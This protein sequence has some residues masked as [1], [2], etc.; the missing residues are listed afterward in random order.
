MRPRLTI[1]ASLVLI[2]AL[3]LYPAVTSGAEAERPL[4]LARQV[5]IDTNG[6]GYDA[7]SV[8]VPSDWAFGGRVDWQFRPGVALFYLQCQAQS[9]D[10]SA[11]FEQPT[12]MSFMWSSDQ[13]MLWSFQQQGIPAMAPVPLEAFMRQAFLPSARSAVQGLKVIQVRPVPEEA[14][15]TRRMSEYLQQVIYA[16]SP[17]STPMQFGYE[18][19]LVEV[20]YEYGGQP[21]L[22]T[23][24]ATLSL[25]Q[26]YTPGM[27]GMVSVQAWEVSVNSVRVRRDRAAGLAEVLPVIMRS[28]QYNPR[29][30]V[31][32]AR[33]SA[34]MTR[35]ALQ[36][37]QQIAEAMSRI[38]SSQSEIGDMITEGYARR[39]ATMDRMHERHVQ[40]IR[41]VETYRSPQGDVQRVELP[42]GYNQAWTNGN[43]FILSNDPRFDPAGVGS[44]GWTAMERDQR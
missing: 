16:I 30:L 40:A 43:E 32:H 7:F 26:S 23:F 25:Q 38:A 34:T 22:E 33:L 1:L 2:L 27:T 12:A 5:V 6:F 28:A 35:Q 14:E 10:G 42:A 37:Q 29:W 31:D 11:V 21:W 9:P 41:G 19:A 18:A 39:S 4:H 20:E 24:L 44:G 13:M 36:H 3:L 17:P 8:L 15:R